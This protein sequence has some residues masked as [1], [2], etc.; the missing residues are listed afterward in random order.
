MIS[1]KANIFEIKNN[2]KDNSIFIHLIFPK[3]ENFETSEMILKLNESQKKGLMDIKNIENID[4]G[5]KIKI[6]S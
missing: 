6:I 1:I 5:K 3:I 2:K 4:Y